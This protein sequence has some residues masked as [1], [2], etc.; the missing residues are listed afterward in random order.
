MKKI[1]KLFTVT[2]LTLCAVSCTR[3]SDSQASSS[4]PISDS[5]STPKESSE[6]P[7]STPL[8]TPV[9]S[10]ELSSPTVSSSEKDIYDTPWSAKNVDMM[11]KYLGGNVLEASLVH[12]MPQQTLMG[13]FNSM[14][15][16]NT[17]H[18][19]S[20]NSRKPSKTLPM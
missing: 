7:V 13:N 18:P 16:M 10:D 20:M 14:K 2:L 4:S 15:S 17:I 9:T 6:T 19:L 3:N 5:F 8:S 1:A 11:I 12:G